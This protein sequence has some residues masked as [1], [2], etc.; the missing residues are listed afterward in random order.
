[1]CVQYTYLD[2]VPALGLG[3]VKRTPRSLD[4]KGRHK[5]VFTYRFVSQLLGALEISLRALVI[6][7]PALLRSKIQLFVSY[8]TGLSDN[9]NTQ[10]LSF[11]IEKLVIIKMFLSYKY[12]KDLHSGLCYIG[13]EI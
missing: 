8:I 2:I 12:K 5:R 1:M 3:E 10:N 7:E 4:N 13:F 9:C 6:Q 11:K